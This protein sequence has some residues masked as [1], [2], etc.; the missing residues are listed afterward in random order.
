MGIVGAMVQTA[1]SYPALIPLVVTAI[2][3]A[4]WSYRR[5]RYTL[6]TLSILLGASLGL[7]YTGGSPARAFSPGGGLE[8]APDMLPETGGRAA[9]AATAGGASGKNGSGAGSA[10][11]GRPAVARGG[12]G[13]PAIS[14]V[15]PHPRFPLDFPIPA[16]FR[17]ESN[18]GGAPGGALS[19]RFRFRGEGADAVRAL[20][21]LG[22][23]NGWQVGQT[24]PH[25]L[26]LKKDTRTVEAWF[27]YPAHSVV[28]DIA[29][30][31]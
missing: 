19:V 9:A 8:P 7:L 12:R 21:V 20:K 14:R 27:S 22:E 16:I 26:I 3:A 4:V 5:R 13:L 28:L 24:A 23:A 30:G 31:R 17:P 10:A 6:A 29:E 11:G 25:R 15:R 1:Q 18:S 2:G